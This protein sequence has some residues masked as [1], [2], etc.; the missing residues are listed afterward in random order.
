MSIISRQVAVVTGASSGIGASFAREFA[1]RGFDLLLTA[2]NKVKLNS[3]ADELGKQFNITVETINVD[4]SQAKE[5]ES[6]IIKIKSINHVEILVNNAGYGNISNFSDCH[7][8]DHLKMMNV[9]NQAVIKLCYLVMPKMLE[10][11]SGIIIN[12]SSIGS[13]FPMKMNAI[14]S[15]SKAFVRLFTESLALELSKTGIQIQALC[16][17]LTKTNFHEKLGLNLKRLYRHKS[18][19]NNPMTAD[20]VTQKSLKALSKNRVTFIPGTFNKLFTAATLFLNIM[21]KQK[22]INKLL[23]VD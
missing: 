17:G 19:F 18:F 4:L 6:F 22:L 15:G 1:R 5:L 2:K 13:F 7:L 3:F 21:W 20:K 14:Y 12:V 16:P 10:R 8:N 23:D 11:N 9:H